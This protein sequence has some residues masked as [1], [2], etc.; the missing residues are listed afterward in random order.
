VATVGAFKL[1]DRGVPPW[2]EASLSL[3]ATPG[4]FALTVWVP[5]LKRLGL[6]RGEMVTVPDP[7]GFVLIAALYALIVFAVVAL[8]ARV[9]RR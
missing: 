8:L 2:L 9:I 4:V 3:A 1:I 7:I 6:T 5:L